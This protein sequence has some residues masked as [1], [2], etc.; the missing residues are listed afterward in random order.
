MA[1]D[2]ETVPVEIEDLG[3]L[4]RPLLIR[5]QAILIL[6][7]TE[8][9]EISRPPPMTRTRHARRC[10]QPDRLLDELMAD[11]E[12][13]EFYYEDDPSDLDEEEL[14]C[15][16]DEEWLAQMADDQLEEGKYDTERGIEDF[17]VGPVMCY[18]DDQD[19]VLTDQSDEEVEETYGYTSA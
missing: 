17:I 11:Q 15:F 19:F 3:E 9:K 12:V 6:P 10:R 14:A 2:D 16:S 7:D 4:S 8:E 13:Q 1:S 18:S 5:Q